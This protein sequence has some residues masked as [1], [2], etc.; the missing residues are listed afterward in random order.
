MLITRCISR[1]KLGTQS[2][3]LTCLRRPTGIVAWRRGSGRMFNRHRFGE[4]DRLL[5][6]DHGRPPR[7]FSPRGRRKSLFEFRPVEAPLGAL[8]P[9]RHVISAGTQGTEIQSGSK[10]GDRIATSARLLADA[11]ACRRESST[12]TSYSPGSDPSGRKIVACRRFRGSTTSSTRSAESFALYA[13]RSS[14]TSTVGAC[15]SVDRVGRTD[16][17]TTSDVV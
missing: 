10:G 6:P 5:R 3:S 9:D 1:R 15:D 7:P 8:A 13:R 12:C 14:S 17:V 4:R 2:P 11:T 16:G